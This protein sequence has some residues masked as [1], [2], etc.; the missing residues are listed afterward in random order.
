VKSREIILGSV[1]GCS[2]EQPLSR[3]RESGYRRVENN[4]RASTVVNPY[5]NHGKLRG[6]STKGK[7]AER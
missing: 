4:L 5:L 1:G 6:I 7:G 2:K 3:G